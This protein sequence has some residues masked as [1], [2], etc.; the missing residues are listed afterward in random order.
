MNAIQGDF[1]G[2][3]EAQVTR[4]VYSRDLQRILVPVGTKVLGTST[5][6]EGPFQERLAVGFHR[7]IFPDGRWVA[8]EGPGSLWGLSAMGESSLKDQVDRHYFQAFGTAGAVGLLS[9]LSQGQ[10]GSQGYG[11]QSALSQN[12]GQLGLQMMSRFLNRRPTVS[13][14][15]GH[16]LNIRMMTDV[17][18]PAAVSSNLD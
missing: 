8:L 9:A 12:A 3:V 13:I 18:I 2:P 11:V 15:A 5:G 4:P 14:R 1:T 10:G 16:R 7:M 6:T 17:I